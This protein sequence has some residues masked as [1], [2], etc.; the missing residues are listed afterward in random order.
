VKEKSMKKI[1]LVCLIA[2]SMFV[3]GC[4]AKKAQAEAKEAREIADQ[5][6]KT[7]SKAKDIAMAADERSQRNEEI[8]NRHFKKSMYK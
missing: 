5:A 7:A 3:S 4:A 2:A 8:L 1:V 6:Y